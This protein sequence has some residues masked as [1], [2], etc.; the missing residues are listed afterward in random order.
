MEI[1]YNLHTVDV[2]IPV[3]N[4]ERYIMRA[5]E[6][7]S[8][9]TFPPKSII[10]VDD[11]STDNTASLLAASSFGIPL[12]V[13]RQENRGL[14]SAR[15]TGIKHSTSKFV[16]FLDADDEW[17]PTKLEEQLKVFMVADSERNLGVVYCNYREIDAHGNVLVG[18]PL[19]EL[20]G[21]IFTELLDGNRISGSGSSVLAR[22]DCFIQAGLFD[23][24]LK[25][26]EDWD[27]WLRLA[28]FFEFD[29]T[30]NTLVKI[31]KHP[32]NMQRNETVMFM[33]SLVF[34][35]KWSMHVR[36]NDF[37]KSWCLNIVYRIAED[38]PSLKSL[39]LTKTVLSEGS[40]KILFRSTFGC[41]EAYLL[42]KM[43]PILIIMLKRAFRLKEYA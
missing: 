30:P 40:K 39:R 21:K 7:A 10:V 2:I 14:S 5:V 8:Y 11:G 9:Q 33:N 25:A 4:G 35:D 32:E 43:M 31:R 15:N 3:F 20:R 26:C 23:E 37:Y 22:R 28:M 24:R 38:L 19:P 41:V 17:Y 6:T 29:F 42:L 12:E 16:A 34:Y 27:M 1:M 18:K 36:S 13:I